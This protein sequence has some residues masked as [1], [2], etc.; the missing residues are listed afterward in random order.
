MLPVQQFLVFA[1][2]RQPLIEFATCFSLL[3]L[4]SGL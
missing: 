2:S 4:C 3:E 1:P